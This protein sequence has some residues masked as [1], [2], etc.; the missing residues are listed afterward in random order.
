MNIP[1]GLQVILAPEQEPDVYSDP[2]DGVIFDLD[3][4]LRVFCTLEQAVRIRD[5]IDR[6]IDVLADEP[7][8]HEVTNHE[9]DREA[10]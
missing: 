1:G 4:D 5:E 3:N 6:M 7:S 10:S 2:V 9:L 8:E